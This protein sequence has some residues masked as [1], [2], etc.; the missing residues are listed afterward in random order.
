LFG[1]Y[2][3]EE[4]GGKERGEKRGGK[5]EE[6]KE[7]KEEEEDMSGRREQRTDNMKIPQ[8]PNTHTLPCIHMPRYVRFLVHWFKD[9]DDALP[10]VAEVVRPPG[11][12][13]DG[14]R[15]HL[16]TRGGS[17]RGNGVSFYT[18]ILLHTQ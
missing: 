13:V 15:R 10:S 18:T 17:G 5:R 14:N 11:A 6:G 4:K 2:L 8:T 1:P 9:S 16:G 3:G 7:N 12:E